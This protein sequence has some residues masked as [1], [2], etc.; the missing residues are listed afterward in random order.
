M[1]Q[2]ILDFFRELA[3][4]GNETEEEEEEVVGRFYIQ[5]RKAEEK[6]KIGENRGG[7]K[8]KTRNKVDYRR[9]VSLL[10]DD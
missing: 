1:N 2:A 5:G 9:A 8:G 6:V 4:Q 7:K 3:R 10:C